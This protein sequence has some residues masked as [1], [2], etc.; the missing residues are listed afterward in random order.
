MANKKISQLSTASQLFTAD[1]IPVVQS[2]ITK[3]F[4]MDTL[5]NDIGTWTQ[6]QIDAALAGL[7][8]DSLY[9]GS[10]DIPDETEATVREFSFKTDLDGTYNPDARFLTIKTGATVTPANGNYTLAPGRMSIYAGQ[11]A[12]SAATALNING[13]GAY[14][15]LRSSTTGNDNRMVIDPFDIYF[16]RSMPSGAIRLEVSDNGV[17][18][19]EL[20][21]GANLKGFAYNADYSADIITKDRSIPDVGTVKVL[22]Q[23]T[24]TWTTAG[25]PGTPTAGTIGFNTSTSKFEG[26]DGTSW[27]DLH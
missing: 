4:T 19:T 16:E 17:E 24:N 27:V 20:R 10:G 1:L 18:V 8:F 25:R 5:R 21:S 15:E 11:V 2:G 12:N 14:I 13:N 7:T 9:T 23:Q 6:A 26:Y 3:N 22:R